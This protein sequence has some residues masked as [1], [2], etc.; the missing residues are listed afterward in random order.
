M[1]DKKFMNQKMCDMSTIE[2]AR[3]IVI[4][5]K[6]TVLTPAP[7]PL[8]FVE[9]IQKFPNRFERLTFEGWRHLGSP[10]IIDGHIEVLNKEWN[11][12][13]MNNNLFYIKFDYVYKEIIRR[14]EQ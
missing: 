7:Q 4:K 14:K 11:N 10:S 8:T 9:E 5:E 13:P 1:R 6:S 12:H 2:L 3:A